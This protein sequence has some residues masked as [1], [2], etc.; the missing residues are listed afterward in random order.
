[1]MK[2]VSHDKQMQESMNSVR[3][4]QN[5]HSPQVQIRSNIISDELKQAQSKEKSTC[6]KYET[7]KSAA[8][9]TIM[10]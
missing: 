4:W 6:I 2:S 10:H 9:S 5:L 3:C 1:M 7:K 8:Y